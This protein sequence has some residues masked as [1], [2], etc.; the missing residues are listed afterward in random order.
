MDALDL[1]ADETSDVEE[2]TVL[3]S[4]PKFVSGGDL[5]PEQAG[6][7]HKPLGDDETV[8]LEQIES[9]HPTIENDLESSSKCENDFENKIPTAIDRFRVQVFTVM[10]RLLTKHLLVKEL[11]MQSQRSSTRKRA[12]KL[13]RARGIHLFRLIQCHHLFASTVTCV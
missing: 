12:I 13:R 3:K 4:S 9:K 7:W 10:A 2:N 11:Q 8:E 1:F 5:K 6:G